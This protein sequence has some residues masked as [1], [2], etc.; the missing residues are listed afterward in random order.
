M[1][2][3]TSHTHPDSLLNYLVTTSLAKRS[4]YFLSCELNYLDRL[5]LDDANLDEFRRKYSSEAHV[6]ILFFEEEFRKSIE[7]RGCLFELISI[8]DWELDDYIN[9]RHKALGKI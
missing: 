6:Y 4:L 3:A 8:C 1:K 2:I 7:V 9:L 5:I